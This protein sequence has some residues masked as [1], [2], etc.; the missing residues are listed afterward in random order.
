M[1]EPY[2]IDDTVPANT[3]T[4]VDCHTTNSHVILAP[5]REFLIG[6]TPQVE[7]KRFKVPLHY[8]RTDD[9]IAAAR[10]RNSQW[11]D[12][13]CLVHME[14]ACNGSG[15]RIPDKHKFTVVL[16]N[17]KRARIIFGL[18]WATDSSV[19]V[20]QVDMLLLNTNKL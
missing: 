13:A 2:D 4:R 1:S 17:S 8:A 20:E 9:P 18:A 3:T 10:Y 11:P 6:W 14:F 5:G 7:I 19:S 15:G 16:S 12:Q